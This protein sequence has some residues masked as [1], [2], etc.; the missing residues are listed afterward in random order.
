MEGGI[1]WWGLLESQAVERPTELPPQPPPPMRA[2]F[3]ASRV[4]VDSLEHVL[5]LCM[6][7]SVTRLENRRRKPVF[8][9]NTPERFP[10]TGSQSCSS[11]ASLRLS[12]SH[13]DSEIWVFL[14]FFVTYLQPVGSLSHMT[15]LP[16]EA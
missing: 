16:E 7:R 12:P 13:L 8:C 11:L 3:L 6:N 5:A 10:F 2:R 9:P 1:E 4:I 15:T 14:T